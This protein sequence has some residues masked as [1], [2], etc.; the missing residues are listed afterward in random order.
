M[1]WDQKK[2]R[3]L[4]EKT[5][6]ISKSEVTAGMMEKRGARKRRKNKYHARLQVFV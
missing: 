4:E 1:R 2:G 6:P 3:K 5:L